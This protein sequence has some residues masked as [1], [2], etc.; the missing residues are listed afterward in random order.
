MKLLFYEIQMQLKHAQVKLGISQLF[1]LCSI[2]TTSNTAYKWYVIF[3]LLSL[4]LFKFVPELNME[5]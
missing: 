1:N 3:L 2:V 5:F 4:V